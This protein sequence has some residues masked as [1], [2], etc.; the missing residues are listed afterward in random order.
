MLYHFLQPSFQAP[1]Q[2]VE[3]APPVPGLHPYQQSDLPAVF[4]MPDDG[5]KTDDKGKD[6]Q[7]GSAED[8]DRNKLPEGVPEIFRLIMNPDCSDFYHYLMTP[9]HEEILLLRNGFR[10]EKEISGQTL[11]RTDLL[12]DI[13]SVDEYRHDLYELCAMFFR[14]H[15]VGHFHVRT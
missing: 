15:G 7:E 4:R 14:T 5:S 8:T 11:Y 12:K 2:Q 13:Q 9:H 3:G 6:K 1:V 10:Q